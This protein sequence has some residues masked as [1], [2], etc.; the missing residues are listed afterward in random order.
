MTAEPRAPSP[1]RPCRSTPVDDAPVIA[2]LAA[3]PGFTEKGSAVALASGVVDT[4][5]D[6]TL[7]TGA[8]VAI[9]GGFVAGD[10][11]NVDTTGTAVTATY[12][13][14]TGVLTLT[15]LDT[16][17][18]YQHVLASVT[19]ST[20]SDNPSNFGAAPTR[21]ITWSV[22][23]LDQT[24]PAHTNATATATTHIAITAINDAPVVTAGNTLDFNANTGQRNRG[25]SGNP[26]CTTSTA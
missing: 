2:G 14:T 9:T 23:D 19:F 21:D 16:A 11:L 26:C 15:G 20:P 5:V 1:P 6:S 8:K 22:T 25:R 17:I 4:D 3:N 12:D 7:L 13:G 10:T 18:D 24:S